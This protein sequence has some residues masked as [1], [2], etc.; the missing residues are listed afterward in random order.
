MRKVLE[1]SNR[2]KNSYLINDFDGQNFE[3]LINTG[4]N[5]VLSVLVSFRNYL[6]SKVF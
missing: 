1:F 3:L 2:A 5:N 6:I 4:K